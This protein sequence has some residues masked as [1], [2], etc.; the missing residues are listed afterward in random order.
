MKKRI[1]GLYNLTNTY[2]PTRPPFGLIINPKEYFDKYGC[3]YDQQITCITK[4]PNGFEE[5]C[6]ADFI[7]NNG[8]DIDAIASLVENG[9]K[10]SVDFQKFTETGGDQ[11][12]Y[13]INGMPIVD[14][15]KTNY[16]NSI[17]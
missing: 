16:P 10:F 8:S 13:I 4:V 15:I 9:F 1:F 7:Y 11:T 2:D 17:V 5:M 14:Y 12:P 6:E 3:S